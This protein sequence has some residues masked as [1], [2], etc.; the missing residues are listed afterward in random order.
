M[1][2]ILHQRMVRG[3]DGMAGEV[4]GGIHDERFR[5]AFKD[6]GQWVMVPSHQES[7]WA[8]ALKPVKTLRDEEKKLVAQAA[9]AKLRALV[10]HEP[11]RF[12]EPPPEDP[13]DGGLF[14]VIME[15]L[16]K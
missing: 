4:V 16:S 7:D 3:S 13:F 11:D 8:P 5:I 1:T 9:D 15:Y 6:R 10:L 12:W 2:L 14:Q